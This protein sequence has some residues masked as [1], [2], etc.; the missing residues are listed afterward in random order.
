M[1]A[2]AALVDLFPTVVR[3]TGGGPGGLP[4]S[5]RS[6]PAAGSIYSETLYPRFHFGWSD[7]AS[8]ADGR[9]HYIH[10]PRPEFYDWASDPGEKKDLSREL[11]AP[12]RA[13]RAALSGMSRPLTAPGVS[14]PETVKK[15]ASLGYIS[16][17]SAA[18]GRSDLPDPRDRI[19]A[20]ARLKE[21]SRLSSAGKPGQAVE[22]LSALIRESP[23]MLDAREALARVF[24]WPAG[25]PTPSTPF[26]RR[27]V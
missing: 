13:M 16:A 1:T 18:A 12:F 9:F 11:S 25:P 22:V 6:R 14:D 23:G 26:S 19:G 3:A 8:L 4:G 27:T 2:A 17:T 24:R 5:R 21:A 10:G 7:L 20:L 15:L